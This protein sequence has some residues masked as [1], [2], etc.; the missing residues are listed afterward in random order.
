LGRREIKRIGAA[1]GRIKFGGVDMKGDSFRKTILRR[2]RK[3]ERVY[4]D[5]KRPDGNFIRFYGVIVSVS[6]DLPVGLQH[7]KLGIEFSVEYII[8]YNTAG[9]WVKKQS[10]GGDVVDE[11]RFSIQT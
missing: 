2:Q 4:Y 10:L 3:G 7:P 1:G 11:P 8:E 6:E 9:S 5:F